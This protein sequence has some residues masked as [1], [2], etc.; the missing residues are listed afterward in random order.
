MP[1]SVV[2]AGIKPLFSFSSLFYYDTI[3]L[4]LFFSLKVYVVAF[5]SSMNVNGWFKST[6]LSG[7]T[8]RSHASDKALRATATA[9]T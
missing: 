3:A 2:N 9:I 7:R 5:R 4:N 6:L 8:K 1:W